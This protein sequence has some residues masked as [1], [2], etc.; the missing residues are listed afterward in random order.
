MQ[1][2]PTLLALAIGFTAMSAHAATIQNG[3]TL[4][5]AKGTGTATSSVFLPTGGSYFKML[6]SGGALVNPGTAA[7][8]TLGGTSTAGQYDNW[9]FFFKAGADFAS[10][11]I[12]VISPTQI[13]FDGW[14]VNYNGANIDM[15]GGAWQ[16]NSKTGQPVSGDYVAGPYTNG[17]ANFSWDGNYAHAY[18]LT[19]H[20]TVPTNVPGFG[21]IQ[22]DLNLTGNVIAAPV[23]EA[24][25]YGMMVVGLGLVGAAVMRRRK[26]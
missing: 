16:V 20:A 7:G 9:T 2:K 8:I 15:T 19:Y 17:V 23:P 6:G 18:T 14:F 3:D 21:G 12:S 10:K 1:F 4:T 13:N 5:I 11:P 26:V 24:S 22:Y 25:T